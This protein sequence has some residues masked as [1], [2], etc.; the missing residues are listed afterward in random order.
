MG[1]VFTPIYQFAF[2]VNRTPY[3]ERKEGLKTECSLSR[4][5]VS[6]KGES[7]AEG[8][9]LKGFL[10]KV[11]E[12]SIRKTESNFCGQKLYRQV[13]LCCYSLKSYALTG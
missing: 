6:S 9:F 8:R 13:A 3:T 5:T 4:D 12:M 10:M 1:L 2:L 7:L 11:E